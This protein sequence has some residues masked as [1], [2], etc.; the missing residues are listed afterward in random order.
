MSILTEFPGQRLV[1]NSFDEIRQCP[2][3]PSSFD[4][5]VVFVEAPEEKDDDRMFTFACHSRSVACRVSA[6]G[7]SESWCAGVVDLARGFARQHRLP[8]P[9][10]PFGWVTAAATVVVVG[11][12]LYRPMGLND[13]IT[14][15]MWFLASGSVLAALLVVLLAHSRLFPPFTLVLQNEDRWWKK[16]NTELTLAA[17]VIAAIAAVASVLVSIFK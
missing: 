14:P 8:Y 12:G 1:F 10:I 3:L 2:D 11:S 13:S 17:T 4:N 7:P 6:S 5:V 16:H 9:F 15:P